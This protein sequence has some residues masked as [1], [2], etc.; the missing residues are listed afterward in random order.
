MP[1]TTIIGT[2]GLG[3]AFIRGFAT[4]G[5]PI[6]SIFNRTL[7]KV[8]PLVQE[9]QV[10]EKGT[11]PN[12]KEELGQIIFLTVP[13]RSI[14]QVADRLAS[15]S[16]DWS[17][18][19]IVHCSG[20]ESAHL[21]KEL[22]E[23]GGTTASFH[24]LQTFPPGST[25]DRFEDIYFSMQGDNSAFPFLKEIAELLGAHFFQVNEE[26]KSHLHAAAVMASNYVHTILDA[27][28]NTAAL[29]DLSR[30]ESKKAL[31]PLVQQT[32]T[33]A[34]KYS[35]EE[36]LTGPIQRGDLSTVKKHLQLLEEDE[37]LRKIYS[38]LGRN[39]VALALRSGAITD[40]TA[41]QFY[42]ILK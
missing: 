37:E 19:T 31:L 27:A 33:N 15:L 6:K 40:E 39:T 10:E 25:S 42:S 32:V 4:K 41:D 7:A 26:Q 5:I 20:N 17:D 36:A 9:V 3:S 13:D 24:P 29:G 21:L 38:Q 28:V 35:L 22:Q 23:K 30:G 2:G 34:G 12:T 14:T 16:D 11:F 8:E 1:D 18:K